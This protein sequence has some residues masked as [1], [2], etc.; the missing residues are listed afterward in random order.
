MTS[1]ERVLAA[2]HHVQPDVTPC[3][4]YSTPEIHRG[5]LDRL[6]APSEDALLDRLGVDIRYISPPYTG[7]RLATFDDG[8]RTDI[9]GIRKKPMPKRFSP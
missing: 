5:L 1:R 7:P 9:W 8:S 6:R 2:L 3:D 4:Y